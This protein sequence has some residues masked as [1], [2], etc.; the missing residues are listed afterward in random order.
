MEIKR[1]MRAYRGHWRASKVENLERVL[2]LLEAQNQTRL[3][4][5][6]IETLNQLLTNKAIESVQ[7]HLRDVTGP[8]PDH[9][10]NTGH[11]RLLVSQY[12]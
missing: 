6:E 8:V 11:T 5:K 3:T 7:A 9:H 1:V 12:T 10:N 4:R 2:P